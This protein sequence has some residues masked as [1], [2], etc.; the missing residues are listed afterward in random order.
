MA[1]V[2][3]G[4]GSSGDVPF[5]G[6]FAEE[7]ERNAAD[8][9]YNALYDR[10][11][12]L[13]LLGEVSGQRVLDVGCGPGLYAEELLARGARV[14][15]FDSSPEMVRLAAGDPESGWTLV[16][17]ASRHRLTGS[18]TGASTSL[19]ALVIHHL[20]DRT[21][22]LRELWRILSPGGRLVV[23]THHPTFPTG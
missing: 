14:V 8:N 15:G 18:R 23:S 22:A 3:L 9:A 7:Y 20:D 13:E 12:V 16:C 21:A 2:M 17:T 19:M 6:S 10:P 4:M 1:A 5:F 11:A